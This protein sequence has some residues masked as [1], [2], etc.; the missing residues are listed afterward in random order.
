MHYPEL[1]LEVA[2]PDTFLEGYCRQYLPSISIA[3]HESSQLI[4]SVL[5]I[6]T[7]LIENLY[8]RLQ[9]FHI[10]LMKFAK[11][12]FDQ[13][14]EELKAWSYVYMCHHFNSSKQSDKNTVLLFLD[15][16]QFHKSHYQ[17]MVLKGTYMLKDGMSCLLLFISSVETG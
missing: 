16:L 6:N 12:L 8:T 5:K 11:D 2:I 17:S 3:D 9:P 4:V 15:S 13:A 14:S 10:I 7:L 1:D